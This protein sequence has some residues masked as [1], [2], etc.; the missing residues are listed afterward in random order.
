MLNARRNAA[1]ISN[2]LVRPTSVDLGMTLH[3]GWAIEGS[4]GSEYKIDACYMSTN[5]HIAKELNQVI[6]FYGI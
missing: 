4:I 2:R 3:V 6:D 5:I 1:A